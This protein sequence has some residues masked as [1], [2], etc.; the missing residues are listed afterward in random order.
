MSLLSGRYEPMGVTGRSI[1]RTLGVSAASCGTL[2]LGLSLLV[3]VLATH[4][5]WRWQSNFATVPLDLG[6]DQPQI[7][8]R[9]ELWGWVA[10]SGERFALTTDPHRCTSVDA[11]ALYRLDSEG[12]DIAYRW[13]GAVLHLYAGRQAVQVSPRPHLLPFP[14]V[15]H[16]KVPWVQ[17][18]DWLRSEGVARFRFERNPPPCV[19]YW[20]SML[21]G[22][23]SLK[24]AL[25]IPTET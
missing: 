15:R 4:L 3:H 11:G 24:L 8:A 1:L 17:D 10:Y 6:R 22:L 16:E 5:F 9:R 12:G 19:S 14:V 13:D 18:D 7:F 25:G 20:E 23:K 2:L 21:P